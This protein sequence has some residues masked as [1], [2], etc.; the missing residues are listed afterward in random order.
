[1]IGLVVTTHGRVG[2]ALLDAC[3]LIV[4]PQHAALAVALER[5]QPLEQARAELDAAVAAVGRDG[6]GVLIMADMFG[7]TPANL[8]AP[9]LQPGRVEVLC[10]VNL[11]MLLKFFNSREGRS[12][13]TLAPLLKGYG[14]Q[15]V[16]LLSELLQAH[17]SP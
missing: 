9:L 2:Q 16:L 8:S 3:A 12:L 17:S 1:M 13:E 5:S 7:G 10:G 6:D 15:G 4:G 11:P 14:Q